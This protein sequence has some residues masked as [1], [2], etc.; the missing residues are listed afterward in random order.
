MEEEGRRRGTGSG[1]PSG[2]TL[3]RGGLLRWRWL[4][5]AGAGATYALIVLGGI[6]RITGSG[7]GC[8]EHWPL[9]NGHLIPP[10]D[11]PT[12]IEYSHR[13]AAVAVSLLVLGVVVVAW[14]PGRGARWAGP[15]RWSLIAAGLLVVQ[16]LLG[17]V[18]VWWSLPAATVVLHLGTVMLLLGALIRA[19]HSAGPAPSQ[20]LTWDAASR[21]CWLTAGFG[22][23]V[24]LAGALVANLGAAP[25]CQGF[26]LCNGRWLPA[27]NWRV[28]LHW[29]HRLLAYGLVLGVLFLPGRARHWRPASPRVWTAAWLVAGTAAAQLAVAAFMVLGGLQDGW[30]A[31]HVALGA[32][33]FGELV[34]L[35]DGVTRTRS[36]GRATAVGR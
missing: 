2:Q 24:V 20:A 27:A 36:A 22:L 16:V 33:L 31:A 13:L 26:P 12:L 19:V 3:P 4:A 25:A 5:L 21:I 30:R 15:R 8:G 6:V 1:A 14:R 34:W 17:A 9:C 28:H 18:T 7:L 11:L 35:A 32:A 10:F 23:G 29:M